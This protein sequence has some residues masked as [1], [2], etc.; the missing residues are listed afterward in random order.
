MRVHPV[1]P[2]NFVQTTVDTVLGD[3]E[4]PAGTGVVVLSRLPATD[5]RWFAA[6]ERFQPSR[7]IDAGGQTHDPSAHLPF[8]SG[9]RICPGR[10]LAMVE[11]RI[12]LATL[13]KSFEIERVGPAET[14]TELYSFTVG[15][16]GLRVRI[17]PRRS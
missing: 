14:V 7:W 6:P 15:P 12:V 11:M 3:V 5:A 2:V 10:T 13:Y 9:P 1:A 16:K 4:L 17:R 8:G